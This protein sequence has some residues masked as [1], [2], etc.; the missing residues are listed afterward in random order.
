M[1]ILLF[2][3]EVLS[4]FGK[5][6]EI[7]YLFKLSLLGVWEPKAEVKVNNLESVL[8]IRR[9]ELFSF[10]FMIASFSAEIQT[11][12][13]PNMDANHWSMNIHADINSE[14]HCLKYNAVPCKAVIVH[15][16]K[17]YGE[18]GW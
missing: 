2:L 10:L 1:V 18:G 16:E 9:R 5:G 11:A 3:I 12:F 4:F 15:V 17:A 14:F 7:I 8:I 13:S 6:T